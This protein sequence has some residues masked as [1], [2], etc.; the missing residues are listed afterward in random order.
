[1]PDTNSSKASSEFATGERGN[2]NHANADSQI[3]T[4]LSFSNQTSG[5]IFG[6]LVA[7]AVKKGNT[8]PPITVIKALSANTVVMNTRSLNSQLPLTAA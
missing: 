8:R 2:N 1:M 6:E 5:S 4:K 3:D 7:R